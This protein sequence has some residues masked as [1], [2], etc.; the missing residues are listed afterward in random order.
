MVGVEV[1]E[2]QLWWDFAPW[3]F[4]VVSMGKGKALKV[5][6]EGED[7]SPTSGKVESE[8]EKRIDEGL[9][10]SF[11][12]PTLPTHL[13]METAF[14]GHGGCSVLGTVGKVP[15]KSLDMAIGTMGLLFEVKKRGPCDE[16]GPIPA[17]V[18]K[19]KGGLSMTGYHPK[20]SAKGFPL[21]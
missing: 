16:Y 10:A 18:L 7:L 15:S 21:G 13:M 12:E 8:E 3:F 11:D 19:L 5:G 14:A 17:Q 4:T 6:D 20:W 1:F 2:I 9:Q